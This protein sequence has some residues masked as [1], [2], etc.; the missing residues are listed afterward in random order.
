MNL[1]QQLEMKRAGRIT[2][3]ESYGRLHHNLL[4]SIKLVEKS[5]EMH[6]RDLDDDIAALEAT[7]GVQPSQPVILQVDE[8]ADEK[9]AA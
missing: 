7:I 1:M 9:Q 2:A 6:L 3:Q 5:A 4:A 8:P